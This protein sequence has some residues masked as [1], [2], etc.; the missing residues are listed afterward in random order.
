[1]RLV[2]TPLGANDGRA[3]NTTGLISFFSDADNKFSQL[4]LDKTGTSC[5]TIKELVSKI[6]GIEYVFTK[7]ALPSA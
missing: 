4:L 2:M 5:S 7:F 6:D 1:M 3:V